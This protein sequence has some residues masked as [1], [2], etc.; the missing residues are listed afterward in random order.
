MLKVFGCLCFS[1][2]L[3]QNRTK[4][5]SK[6]HKCIF[7][8]YKTGTKGFV[9]LNLNNQQIH[10]SRNVYFYES[11]FRFSTSASTVWTDSVPSPQA[12]PPL[13]FSEPSPLSVV[14]SPSSPP[15]IDLPLPR[16]S[17]RSHRPPTYLQDYHFAL[18]CAS[19]LPNSLEAGIYHP[20]SHVLSYHRCS[21]SYHHFICS[22]STDDIPKTYSKAIQYEGWR[23]A[24]HAELAALQQNNTWVI[25][26]L[27]SGKRPIGC[28]WVFAKKY[29]SDGSLNRYKGR[30]VAQ[31]F[32]EVEGLDFNDTFS[33]VAKLTTVRLLLALA[34]AHNWHLKQ[35]DV[36]TA[37]LHGDLDEEVYMLPPPGLVV[38]SSKVCK[39]QRSLYGLKQASRQWYFKLSKALISCGY[40]QSQ[41]DHSLFLKNTTSSFTA[42]LV[43]VDDII[44]SGTDLVEIN[45]IKTFLDDQFK[46]KDLGDVKY[47]LSLEIARNSAGISVCQR[48]FA[49]DLLLD[50]GFLDCKPSQ[51]PMTRNL[52]LSK[53][54]GTYL[55][56][57]SQYRTLVGRLLYLTTTRYFLCCLATLPIYSYSY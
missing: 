36:N 9:T 10:V 38:S 40:R 27:P 3:L 52:K 31:G 29:N 6:A 8:G 49:L 23:N 34:A 50:A 18:Q 15:I 39:L 4:L 12:T 46:I 21:P 17:T 44:L 1:S 45:R 37:F 7:L 53:D 16:R 57:C 20:L 48:K 2:T 54:S 30:L 22:I 33:P 26:D 13:D 47:F 56:D 35:L 24:I 14:P 25:T 41:A 19:I 32:T 5:D 43:Y 28:K 51:T 11:V 42:L 55:T